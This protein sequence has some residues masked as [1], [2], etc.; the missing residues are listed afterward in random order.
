MSFHYLFRGL[1]EII[2]TSQDNS[3]VS[4]EIDQQLMEAA[5]I[6]YCTEREK[7]LA[8]LMDE[9]HIKEGVVYDK[10]MVGIMISEIIS[11]YTIAI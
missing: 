11:A 10:H 6:Q 3:G 2:P 1:F 7:C 8:I 5:K 4:E 9:M